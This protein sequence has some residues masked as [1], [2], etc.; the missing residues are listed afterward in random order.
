[1]IF[2]TEYG[3]TMRVLLITHP[4]ADY[5]ATMFY[6]GLCELIGPENIFD[7]PLKDS[8]HGITHR[9]TQPNGHPGA[10][11][12]VPWCGPWPW[13]YDEGIFTGD[14]NEEWAASESH[15]RSML[16]R[17]EFDLVVIESPRQWAREAYD[18]L[19]G[20][21]D[22]SGATVIFHDGED[23]PHLDVHMPKRIHANDEIRVDLI[24]KRECHREHHR[25][26]DYMRGQV[27]VLSCPFSAPI[28][29]ITN[30]Q[31]G[32]G[33]DLIERDL[34]VVFMCGRTRDI[35]Q[36]VADELRASADLVTA[37]GIQADDA[38][39][40]PPLMRWEDYIATHFRAQ[41]GVSARGHG[42]DTVRFW[43][44][45]ATTALF[46]DDRRLHDPFPYEDGNNCVI[47]GDRKH[48]VERIRDWKSKPDDLATLRQNGINHTLEHHTCEARVRWV[49]GK[50]ADMGKLERW[51]QL[52][53]SEA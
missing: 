45:A 15:V 36:E 22:A 52:Q 12:P 31:N 35:R 32:L 3:L 37:V 17:N 40:S 19:R 26:G 6:E 51:K 18:Q 24:L 53:S 50:L 23:Y 29:N 4:E 34:D 39:T 11:S 46:T 10:T 25:S 7:Y 2:N 21:I 38:N 1:M 14:R 28:R 20:D 30:I 33:V 8:L 43:E 41:I 16:Q 47:W 13:A 49:F 42:M 5:G 48:L 9:Y 44:V 27:R